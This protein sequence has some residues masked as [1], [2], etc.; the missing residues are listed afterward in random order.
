MGTEPETLTV[1]VCERCGDR[2]L[3]MGDTNRHDLDC[4]GERKPVEVVPLSELQDIREELDGINGLYGAMREDY[5]RIEAELQAE[6]KRRGEEERHADE[7]FVGLH[8][9][10]ETRWRPERTKHAREFARELFD[11]HRER[12]SS[13]EDS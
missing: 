9:L 3:D 13:G 6:R 10:M 5:D 12:R 7:L 1:C 8:H 4:G 11:Q 2:R